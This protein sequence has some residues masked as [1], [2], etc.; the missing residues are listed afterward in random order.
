MML[1]VK[2][3]LGRAALCSSTDASQGSGKKEFT[4]SGSIV[5]KSV[6]LLSYK[7]RDLGWI[8]FGTRALEETR[9]C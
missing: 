6:V 8:P 4:D 7:A 3:Y 5:I 2:S 9:D 1:F